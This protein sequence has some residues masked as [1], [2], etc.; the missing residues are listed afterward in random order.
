MP[1]FRGPGACLTWAWRLVF[2][3]VPI[4]ESFPAQSYLGPKSRA[5]AEIIYETTISTVEDPPEAAARFFE[6]QFEQEREGDFAE[7]PPR[8]SQTPDPGLSHRPGSWPPKPQSAC[9]LAAGRV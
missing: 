3:G 4:T 6:P 2:C 8:G 5:L 7:P 9:G 1:R